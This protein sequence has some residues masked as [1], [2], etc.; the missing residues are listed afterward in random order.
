[1]HEGEDFVEGFAGAGFGGEVVEGD[2]GVDFGADADG[3]GFFAGEERVVLLL[4]DERLLRADEVGGE[5]DVAAP[6]GENGVEVGGGGRCEG[7][8]RAWG[9]R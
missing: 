2:E 8:E 9:M 4:V 3:D 1:M 5:E 7:G 6:G